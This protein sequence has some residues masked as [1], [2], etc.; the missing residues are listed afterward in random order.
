MTASNNLERA[1]H[2][3]SERHVSVTILEMHKLTAKT[4]LD[5][6]ASFLESLLGHNTRRALLAVISLFMVRMAKFELRPVEFS[7]LSL[8]LH[9]P[10]ITSRDLCCHLNILPPNLVGMVTGLEKRTLVERVPHPSDGRALGL[11]LTHEGIEL[12]QKAE[13][14]ATQLEQDT[15]ERLTATERKTLIRLLQKVYR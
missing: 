7:V 5:V 11:H 12:T 14:T 8:I 4:T 10:G 6:D 1:M 15:S 13:L 9:N 3:Y 2:D